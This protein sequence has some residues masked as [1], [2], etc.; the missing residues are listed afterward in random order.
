[1]G[2]HD[3]RIKG[4]WL[5]ADLEGGIE[6][7][8]GQWGLIPSTTLGVFYIK[9]KHSRYFLNPESKVARVGLA[10]PIMTQGDSKETFLTWLFVPG[11]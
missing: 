11:P 2:H 7:G 4:E 1:M 5:H 9:N 10:R 6:N 3:C 8:A